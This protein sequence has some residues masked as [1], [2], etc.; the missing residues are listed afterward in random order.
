MKP[1]DKI[2]VDVLDVS[3]MDYGR[4]LCAASLQGLAN[5]EGPRVYLL[6]GIYDDPEARK[7]N[8]VFLP[9]ELWRAKYRDYV[10]DQDQETLRYYGRHYN[11]QVTGQYSLDG[12]I[13]KYRHL[14]KGTV[15][16]DPALPDTV[17]V[18]L[19]LSGLEDL[20]VLHPDM[21]DWAK[22]SFGLEVREDLRGRWKKRAR[23]YR[24]AFEHLFP[25]CAGGKV[26]CI[27][28]GWKRPE[29]TDFVV[30]ERIFTYGLSSNGKGV[31]FSIGQKLLLLMVAGPFGLRNLVFNTRSDA[32]LRRLG[33]GLMGL[34]SPEVRLAN[35]IQRAVKPEPFPTIFGWHTLRDD[36]FSFM[37]QLSANGLRLVPSHLAGNFSFHGALPYGRTMRQ[38]HAPR[39][40]VE[41]DRKK[42]YLTF[43]LSDGDQLVLMSTAQ[44][45][46]WRRAERGRVAFNWEIQ[47][48]LAYMAPALL[49]RFY[50]TR[51]IKDY[52][53]AGPSGAGYVI[54]PLCPDLPA[55]LR[56]SAAVCKKA[57]VRVATSYIGD[58]PI[59][60][61]REH[62]DAPGDFIGFP[63]GYV[64]FGRV[65]MYLAG[66]RPFVANGVPHLDHVGD[67]S[68]DTLAAVRK[69]IEAPG[70]TPRFIGVHLFAYRTTITDV[71]EFVK[72]L[73]ARRVKVV[74]ADEFLLAAGE[75]LRETGGGAV[76]G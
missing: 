54:P 42:I 31:F 67:S 57:D 45:G 3:K 38:F 62:G 69:L 48:L 39:H 75:H 5:R 37:A 2:K 44:L 46:N 73:D 56:Q 70:P 40:E 68:D 14:L 6:Y 19:M 33:L 22:S 49:G 55:Y 65:P 1:N 23:L 21:V 15:V 20:L 4:R 27:E 71:F 74:R 24:W 13:N 32:F 58:P 47:P 72:G 7:T 59:R 25:R 8:E 30:K 66:N 18:A 10:G 11:A 9:D 29:F 16:W 26:A 28:P 64:H 60:V 43:T 34:A 36:E 17:N 76:D 51:S 50:R 53:V 35:R 61:V 52:L 41:L 63:S 12:L